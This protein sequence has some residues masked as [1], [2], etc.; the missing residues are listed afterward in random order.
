MQKAPRL[1]FP[2]CFAARS[3]LAR[4]KVMKTRRTRWNENA[5]SLISPRLFE[6]DAR[7]WGVAAWLSKVRLLTPPPVGDTFFGLIFHGYS[8]PPAAR[9]GLSVGAVIGWCGAAETH[10]ALL[11]VMT[12][13]M[14][15]T[16]GILRRGWAHK[17]TIKP[18][19]ASVFVVELCDWRKLVNRFFFFFF[20]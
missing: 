9:R 2:G 13:K 4:S 11:I 19:N 20:A 15:H 14:T 3:R 12:V 10:G 6:S 18:V 7:T 16:A 5:L 8:L 17:R 1:H